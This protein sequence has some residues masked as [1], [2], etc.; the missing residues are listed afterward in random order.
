MGADFDM[1]IEYQLQVFSSAQS[2]VPIADAKGAAILAANLAFIAAVF[3][4]NDFMM[5]MKH[6]GIHDG[7]FLMLALVVLFFGCSVVS[8]VAALM[9][10]FPRFA[11]TKGRPDAAHLTWFRDVVR[12]AG[13][14]GYHEKVAA[15]SSAEILKEVCCQS[16]VVS[17]I[18]VSKYSY[19]RTALIGLI[20]A[21]AFWI[22][23]LI[24][25]F[26]S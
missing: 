25:A 8:V 6:S 19:T 24:D 17:R 16:F 10:I 18:L 21:F 7:S 20:F 4:T 13:P 23:F 2:L 12:H 1:R 5:T 22:A 9:V 26:R 11:S 15:L 14:E 3:R